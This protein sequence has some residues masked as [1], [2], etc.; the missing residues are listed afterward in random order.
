MQQYK[1]THMATLFTLFF[2]L[3]PVH[4]NPSAIAAPP[5][6]AVMQMVRQEFGDTASVNGQWY[7]QPMFA[8]DT[9][10]GKFPV[11]RID[12]R[13]GTFTGNTGCNNMSGSFR[14]AAESSIVFSKNL[15]LTKMQCTGYDEPAFIKSLMQTNRYQLKNGMLILLFNNT[16]L[17]R[18]TR[19]PDRKI[20]IKHA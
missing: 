12:K 8:A 7:L 3:L 13:S 19:E 17:T 11:L 16:E 4:G 1:S 14:E 18:W 5:A 2:S 6:A 9:A 15:V 20:K 10:A